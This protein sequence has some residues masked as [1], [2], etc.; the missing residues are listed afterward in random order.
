MIDKLLELWRKPAGKAGD[1]VIHPEAKEFLKDY[2]DIFEDTWINYSG[3]ISALIEI[4]ISHYYDV[5]KEDLIRLLEGNKNFMSK[6]TQVF[7]KYLWGERWQEHTEIFWLNMF[8]SEY[9]LK[10][11]I[12][13]RELIEGKVIG[14]ALLQ[15]KLDRRAICDKVEKKG[16]RDG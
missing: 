11:G 3:L 9:N 7:A 6:A 12:L 15:L 14:I 16:G 5:L 1:F 4:S 8:L 13:V 10:I 2:C